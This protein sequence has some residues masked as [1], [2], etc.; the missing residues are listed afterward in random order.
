MEK[1][2]YYEVLGIDHSARKEDIK[3]VYRKLA[4]QYHPDKN[5][6][7]GA[8]EKFKEISEAYAV[9]HD[10]E[11]RKMYDQYGHAGIDQRYTSEDIFRGA[12]F[13]DIFRGRG[14]DFNDI[15]EQFFGGRNR[16]TRH[17]RAQRGN[18]I[19]FDIEI[20][21]EDAYRGMETEL[22]VPRTELCETCR[23]S[24]ARPGS[25]PK[26]CSTCRGSG[27]LQVSRRTA[28]GMFTQI[29]ECSK[30]H[31]Q[32]TF[33]EDPCPSCRGRG[34]LQKI[35][36]I[37]LRIPRG[38]EDGAHLRLA[39]QGE[40]PQGVHQSGDLYVV[41]HMKQHPVFD[42]RGA[43][44]YRKFSISFPQA[45]LGASLS[46]ETL[47]GREHLKI[48]DGTENG[49]LFKIKGSGMPKIHG[50]GSG[51]LYVLIQVTTPKKLNKRAILLLEEL[52]RELEN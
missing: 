42:R 10:D 28:F 36:K 45:S 47:Q 32:G 41:V 30:C 19:R 35:R 8:E 39:G 34:S 15:F 23:G 21:L 20:S 40:N 16:F 17:P 38:I 51:D 27:Q 37:E 31:G 24:G 12:D 9:L 6:D 46:V 33:I 25:S 50:S 13:G 2:D 3:K 43:D 49:T 22:E 26:Q 4:L 29:T 11:K 5:K 52:Q 48:P 44:L 1:K 18:D 7:K 14:F